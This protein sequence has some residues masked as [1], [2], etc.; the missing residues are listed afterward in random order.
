MAGRD[1]PR[2]GQLTNMVVVVNLLAQP[3]IFDSSRTDRDARDDAGD[4]AD[5]R[6]PVG[7]ELRDQRSRFT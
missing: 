7:E 5:Q 3:T 4:P 1:E 6:I 2:L